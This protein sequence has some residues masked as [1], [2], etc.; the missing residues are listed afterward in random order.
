M[1]GA[2]EARLN[3]ETF[4]QLAGFDLRQT[5]VQNIINRCQLKYY[6]EMRVV[7]NH[8]MAN[9][10]YQRVSRSIGTTTKVSFNQEHEND[11]VIV[12]GPVPDAES[13]H[14]LFQFVFIRK[15][16]MVFKYP[17]DNSVTSLGLQSI[18]RDVA[19]SRQL[20]NEFG[21]VECS[22]RFVL[23]Q[24][25][26]VLVYDGNVSQYFPM[27]LGKLSVPLPIR[28]VIHW[29]K[30]VYGGIKMA[31]SI[32]HSINDIKPS[33]LY[34]DA[35]GNCYIADYGAVTKFG[36]YPTAFTSNYLPSELHQTRTSELNDKYCLIATMLQ[37]LQK[38]P[39]VVTIGSLGTCCRLMASD[40]NFIDFV[41]EIF[42]GKNW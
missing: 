26:K 40:S 19:F 22:K 8:A 13:D 9:D 16:L 34:L 3:F 35:D 37:L 29:G 30:Q 25:F 39:V 7:T 12:D 11:D 33:N 15:K 1:F 10:L 28:H 31:H 2:V 4:L 20:C 32:R 27:T 36:E 38:K 23:Y 17:I 21:P 14:S 18:Q 24:S 5:K 6:N 41:N 42:E